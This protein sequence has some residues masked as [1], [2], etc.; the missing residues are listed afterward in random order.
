MEYTIYILYLV[1]IKKMQ[2]KCKRYTLHIMLHIP[3][4][5]LM[6]T[7]CELFLILWVFGW[8]IFWGGMCCLCRFDTI[9]PTSLIWDLGLGRVGWLLRKDLTLCLCIVLGWQGCHA[10]YIAWGSSCRYIK[11]QGIS[12]VACSCRSTSAK[13][14]TRNS[15]GYTNGTK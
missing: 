7:A 3:W 4:P 9:R 11:W 14:K 10:I 1:Y 2:T 13:T 12:S 15:P 6:V 5:C 8:F